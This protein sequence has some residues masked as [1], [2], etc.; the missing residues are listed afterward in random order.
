MKEN[1]SIT[2]YFEDE[3]DIISDATSSYASIRDLIPD[4]ADENEAGLV[5]GPHLDRWKAEKLQQEKAELMLDEYPDAEMQRIKEHFGNRYEEWRAERLVYVA[6]QCAHRGVELPGQ[7]KP[8]KEKKRPRDK[9]LRDPL[10]KKEAME[11]RKKTA[12]FGYT[13]RRPRATHIDGAVRYRRRYITRPTILPV[14]KRRSEE[15]EEE[16][17]GWT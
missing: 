7:K 8:Q 9:V 15:E 14:E 13:Y 10:L 11:V 2:K 16:E 4:D 5:L 12:F 1:Q 17:S 6:E 3:K